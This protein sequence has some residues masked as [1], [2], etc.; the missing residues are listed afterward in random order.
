MSTRGGRLTNANAVF[1]AD[2]WR[3][4][5][6]PPADASQGQILTSSPQRRG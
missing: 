6:S 5:L 3:R 2:R 1:W 4:L